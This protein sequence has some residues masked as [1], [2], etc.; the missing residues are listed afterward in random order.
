[1]R[2]QLM[3][4]RIADELSLFAGSRFRIEVAHSAEQFREEPLKP[5]PLTLLNQ[6]LMKQLHRLA[7]E[8][9]V[10]EVTA[11]GETVRRLVVHL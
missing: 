2:S 4:S 1:M 3:T 9:W 10:Q 5:H 7:D 8:K 11:A 6:P